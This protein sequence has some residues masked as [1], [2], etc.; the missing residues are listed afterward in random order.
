MSQPFVQ[1]PETGLDAARLLWAWINRAVEF[2]FRPIE[3]LF[4]VVVVKPISWLLDR[5]D[6]LSY[7]IEGTLF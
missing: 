5:V 1:S 3:F 4:Y 6:P 2:V 7:K